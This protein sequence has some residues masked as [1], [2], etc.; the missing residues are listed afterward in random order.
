MWGKREAGSERGKESGSAAQDYLVVP[1]PTLTLSIQSRPII[2]DPTLVLSFSLSPSPSLLLPLSSCLSLSSSLSFSLCALLLT[3]DTE[4]ARR[5][6]E[7]P[8][9]RCHSNQNG[10]DGTRKWPRRADDSITLPVTESHPKPCSSGLV[11]LLSLLGGAPAGLI[12][13]L[14]GC[15]C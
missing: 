2:P 9:K 8:E 3:S 7:L 11:A 10:R 15:V 5:D 1:L 13:T 12:A 14:S 4:R 6:R